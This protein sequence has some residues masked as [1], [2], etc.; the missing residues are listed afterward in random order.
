[1]TSQEPAIRTSNPLPTEPEA[2]AIPPAPV[3]AR[4]RFAIACRGP[5]LGLLVNSILVVVKVIAGIAS[6]SVALLA[7]AGHSAADIANNILVLGSLF[8]ASRPADE[9][10]PYGH[11]RAEVLAA[12]AS[13]FILLGAGLYFAWDSI[14]KLITGTPR[15]SL[16]ALWVA[17][18]TLIV[19]VVVAWIEMQIGKKVQSQA[20]KA[21]ARDNMADVLSSLAVII[22][23]WGANLGQ[24]RLDGVAGLVISLLILFNAVQIGL[25]AS[26]EL[27]DQNL[28]TKRLERVRDVAS[29]VEGVQVMA[30]TGREHGS[31]ILLELSIEVDPHMPVDR[32]SA[33]SEEVRQAVY[34]QVP[35]V[36]D[37]VIE[38]NTNHLARLRE[39]L[40]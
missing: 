14:E 3:T 13:A 17:V 29:Q 39:R 23:V 30:V 9:S 32:A 6:G 22:G 1:M 37:V 28:D 36:G 25:G 8:Y 12:I 5:L 16:L 24:P 2:I 31:D 7:D 27:L 19:K 21:D 35:N 38:L 10:H 33:L 40:R 11:D 20:V 18:G 26:H 34:Q 15:A 4:A